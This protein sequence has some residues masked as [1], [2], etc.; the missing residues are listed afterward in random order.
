MWDRVAIEADS[1]VARE[2]EVDRS[3]GRSGDEGRWV[4]ALTKG[5]IE[6]GSLVDLLIEEINFRL[7]IVAGSLF[8][9]GRRIRSTDR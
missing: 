6:A 8:A 4:I 7:A 3:T 9:C 5:A 2:R 1:L